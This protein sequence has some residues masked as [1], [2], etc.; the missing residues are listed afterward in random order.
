MVDHMG[1]T[2]EDFERSR[3]FYEKALAPLGM[4]MFK[5]GDAWGVFGT[6]ADGAFFL[7]VGSIHPSFWHEADGHHAGG[8]PIHF[9]LRAPN[10]QAVDAFHAAAIAAGGRDN[11]APGTRSGLYKYYAAFVLDPDGNNVEATVR[12]KG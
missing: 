9:S 1:F 4:K 3:A 5:G 11:G 8:A 7:W 12:L 2:V 10:P 6:G